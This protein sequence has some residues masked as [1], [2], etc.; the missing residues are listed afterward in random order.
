[1]RLIRFLRRPVV[2]DALLALVLVAWSLRLD[3]DLFFPEDVVLGKL[4]A[5]TGDDQGLR[6]HL[7]WWSLATVP[8]VVGLL[9]RRR[10][11]LPAYALASS[12]AILHLLE[13]DP[14]AVWAPIA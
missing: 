11:P 6:L 13:V 2:V 9:L 10:W 4:G 5:A 1:M 14:D 7:L 8:A 3:S 12:S